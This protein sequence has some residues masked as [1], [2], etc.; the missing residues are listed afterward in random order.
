MLFGPGAKPDAETAA[1][2]WSGVFTG[3]CLKP[4][5]RQ[6]LNAGHP[7]KQ[8]EFRS[9]AAFHAAG[10][11]PVGQ[12]LCFVRGYY[13]IPFVL[14]DLDVNVDI[15]PTLQAAA[16]KVRGGECRR[17]RRRWRRRQGQHVAAYRACG[18]L[19]PTSASSALLLPLPPLLLLHPPVQSAE[20]RRCLH[21]GDCA[22]LAY[23][24]VTPQ[25]QVRLQS[26]APKF[27]RASTRQLPRRVRSQCPCA[28][29]PHHCRWACQ[30]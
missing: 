3:A 11:F 16:S 20:L 13:A 9:P 4:A 27:V 6:Q 30:G 23:D 29:V 14:E 1:E 28:Y 25:S 5:V 24:S 26:A 17:H 8:S 22:A 7:H 10:S 15:S 21:A 12:S 18:M 19:P 2:G